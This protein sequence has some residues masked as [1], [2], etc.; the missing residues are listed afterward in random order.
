MGPVHLA[1][2]AAKQLEPLSVPQSL[3]TFWG[4]HLRLSPWEGHRG[5][6]LGSLRDRDCPSAQGAM[7][8]FCIHHELVASGVGL[9]WTLCTY[10][11]LTQE[12][13]HALKKHCWACF[14]DWSYL[15]PARLSAKETLA[16]SWECTKR[17]HGLPGSACMEFGLLD[18]DSSSICLGWKGQIAPSKTAVR[19]GGSEETHFPSWPCRTWGCQGFQGGA[20]CTRTPQLLC[21]GT[22]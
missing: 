4:A 21:W 11:L 13:P 15:Y 19:R 16:P 18:E 5:L 10:V 7:K 6:Q 3:S 20:P 8:P 12:L 14:T 9:C 1:Q 22:R 2:G 17:H